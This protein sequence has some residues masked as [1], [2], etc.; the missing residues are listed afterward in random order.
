MTDPDTRRSLLTKRWTAPNDNEEDKVGVGWRKKQTS[1]ATSEQV[2]TVVLPNGEAAVQRSSFD[3]CHIDWINVWNQ[4][5][6]RIV[7]PE[8]FPELPDLSF[9]ATGTL[10]PRRVCCRLQCA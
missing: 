7:W 8:T 2:A 3:Q 6:P 4:E 1:L 10:T 5:G 9:Q